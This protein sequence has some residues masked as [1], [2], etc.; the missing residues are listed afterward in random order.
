MVIGQP[1]SLGNIY[2]AG[3]FKQVS[4][5]EFIAFLRKFLST[6]KTTLMSKCCAAGSSVDW[7]Y[8][9]AGIKYSFALEV[10]DDGKWGFL[11]PQ[12]MLAIQIYQKL[13]R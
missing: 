12:V 9:D 8:E 13:P 1:C 10:R 4:S 3:I 6:L 2:T 7:A 11:L 5:R